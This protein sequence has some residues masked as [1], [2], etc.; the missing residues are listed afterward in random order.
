[1]MVAPALFLSLVLGIYPMIASLRMAFLDY[2]LTSMGTRGTPFIG[3]EN[4]RKIF[5]DPTFAQVLTNTVLFLVIVVSL[6]VVLGLLVAM[7]LHVD[8]RGRGFVRSLALIPWFIPPVVASSIWMVLFQPERSPI[9]QMLRALGITDYNLKF[10]TEATQVLGP[11]TVPMLA[12]SAVR[13]WTGLSFATI[14]ILAGLQSIPGEMY[15]AAEIDGA[16]VWTKFWFLTLPML[17]PVLAVLITLLS[18]GSVGHFEINYI[19]TAGGPLNAT[20]ILAVK[21]YAEAFAFFRFGTAAA[22]S[23]IIL[24]FTSIIAFFYIREQVSRRSS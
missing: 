10:L 6:V 2:N 14:M 19:M 12:V 16:N 11:I 4:Y 9:N 22:M 1:M 24:V 15:E 20:N 3:L 5:S 13:V 7:A 18:I 21:T 17:R 23:S 8:F